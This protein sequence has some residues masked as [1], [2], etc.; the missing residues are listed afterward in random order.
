VA[1]E[2]NGCPERLD[3]PPALAKLAAEA[4]CLFS[5]SSDAHAAAH[6]SFLDFGLAVAR[7]AGV[8]PD[9]VVNTWSRDRFA[10]WL[11]ERRGA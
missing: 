11:E 5:I 9:R 1:V 4:G 6:L 10:D 2:L 8:S 7:L 3:L